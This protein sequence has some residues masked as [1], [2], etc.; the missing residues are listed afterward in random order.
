MT[1]VWI[2]LYLGQEKS[3][4]VFGISV[5]VNNIDSLRKAVKE[6]CKPKLDYCAAS[7]LVVYAAGTDVPIPEGTE[8]LDPWD[9]VPTNSTGPM[10][11]IVVAPQ[12]EVSSVV[13]SFN[14]RP[15][16]PQFSH[17]NFN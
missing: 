3:G 4:D 16:S 10:P 6:E 13:S 15:H 5:P 2:Q 11:L 17:S 1:S 8:S 9:T 7:D 12:K 14:L